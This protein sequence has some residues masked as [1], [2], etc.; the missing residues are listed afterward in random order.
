MKPEELKAIIEKRRSIFP[1]DY[2]PERVEDIVI[3]EMLEISPTFTYRGSDIV[4]GLIIQLNEEFK[5]EVST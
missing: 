3:E 4:R 1:K 5:D 2:S